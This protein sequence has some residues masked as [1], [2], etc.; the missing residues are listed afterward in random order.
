[1]TKIKLI[2]FDLDDTLFNKKKEITPATLEALERA[3]NSGIELVPATGR[4]WDAVPANVKAIEA[5]RYAK[6]NHWR[7]TK[8]L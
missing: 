2:A 4:F 6:K 5:I 1:M 7:K 8:S 3:A